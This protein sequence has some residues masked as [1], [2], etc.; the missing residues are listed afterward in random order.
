MITSWDIYWITR[1]DG[2]I[3]GF[4]VG[5]FVSFLIILLGLV[6]YIILISEKVFL[7]KRQLFLLLIIPALLFI[8]QIFIPSTKEMAAIIILPKIANSEIVQ[9]TGQ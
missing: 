1:L 2:I 5:C 7:F 8:A 9:E 6:G 3:V 4:E